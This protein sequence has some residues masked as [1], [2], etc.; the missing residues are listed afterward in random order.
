MLAILHK[1]YHPQN[2]QERA[3]LN[4]W[5]LLKWELE[6]RDIYIDEGRVNK[7]LYYI[8]AMALNRLEKKKW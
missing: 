2:L 1:L 4:N 6:R 8:I 3:Q 5:D 7:S